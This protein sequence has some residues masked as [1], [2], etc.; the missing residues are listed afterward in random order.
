M[1]FLIIL[2]FSLVRAG[3]EGRQSQQPP[4]LLPK[5]ESQFSPPVGWVESTEALQKLGMFLPISPLS[6][7]VLSLWSALV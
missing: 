2:Q 3:W 5:L 7:T 1:I 4:G 6:P